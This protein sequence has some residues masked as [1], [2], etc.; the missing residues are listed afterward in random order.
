[1]SG[2]VS[3]GADDAPICSICVANY[4]GAAVLRACLESILAQDCDFAFEVIVHDDASTDGSEALVTTDFPSVR[5]IRSHENAGFCVANNRMVTIARG[6]YVLLL[7]NDAEL[8][9]DALRKLYIA[10]DLMK[11]P[12]IL[13]L[14]QYDATTGDLLDRGSLLDPFFNPVPNSDIRRRHVATIM[15]SCLWIPRTFWHEIGGFPEWFGSIGEDLYLCCCARLWGA[16]VQVLDE[17]GYWHHV[18][19]SFGGG[20][21]IRGRMSTSLRR[22]ALSERNKTYVMVATLPAPLIF[23]LFPIHL[24]LLI[25]EGGLL[26]V[27]KRQVNLLDAVYLSCVSELW[28]NRSG[29]TALRASR[30]ARRAVSW[31]RFL[32][33]FTPVP[34]K[35]QMLLR[36]GIPE[37]REV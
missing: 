33:V 16:D 22:R 12:C 18:G 8:F 24:L 37:V 25:I 14:P 7:N 28:R 36:H 11:K 34:Y 5:L 6:R 20:K 27:V 17:S 23:A 9:P 10:A 2:L 3:A 4:N 32:C 1:M 13:G 21:V 15:G 26:A 31:H 19:Q 29:L 35:L 30:Q